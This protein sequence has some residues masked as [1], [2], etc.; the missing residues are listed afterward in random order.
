MFSALLALWVSAASASPVELARA[1]VSGPPGSLELSAVR[2][3]GPRE[4][5]IFEQRHLGLPV[6]GGRVVVAVQGGA[7]SILADSALRDLPAVLPALLSPADE[8]RL[9]AAALP[10]AGWVE[11]ATHQWWRGRVIAVARAQS[12]DGSQIQ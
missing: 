2:R 7:A 4:V 12:L 11:P 1:A 8:A 10:R 9:L 6:A 3:Q 5:V